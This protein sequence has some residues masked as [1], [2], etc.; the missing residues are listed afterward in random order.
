MSILPWVYKPVDIPV[1]TGSSDN[2]ID[3]TLQMVIKDAKSQY[4][5]DHVVFRKIIEYLI[6]KAFLKD[7][8]IEKLYQLHVLKVNQLDKAIVII[9][10]FKNY[11]PK[12]DLSQMDS[13]KMIQ[14]THL[15][16]QQTKSHGW[17]P[18]PDPV[19]GRP[20]LHWGYCAHAGCGKTL[21]SRNG[22]IQHLQSYGVYIQGYHL[23][24]EFAVESQQL[25]PEKVLEQKITKC[26]SMV[27]GLSK[28]NSPEELC[29]HLMIL[30]IPPF[31]QQ[32]MV[33]QPPSPT[34]YEPFQTIYF[35]EECIICTDN[36]PSVLF[37]PC[38]H[39]VICFKCCG[40]IHTINKCPKCRGNITGML[41][42]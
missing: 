25:T 17:Y 18:L 14:I 19:K 12:A 32:G 39:C 40:G 16:I 23:Q 7:K 35:E 27:C 21:P 4:I 22:L 36:T 11:K 13:N 1:P 8:I 34:L 41:V 37:L 15:Q 28:F 2:V 42:I 10:S 3:Y 38:N 9:D 24:H 31:W 29:D 6:L 30:G 20:S 33:I 5:P 26:P